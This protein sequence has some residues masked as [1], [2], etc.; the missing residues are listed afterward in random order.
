MKH[1]TFILLIL[2]LIVVL[3]FNDGS[4]PFVE[5]KEQEIIDRAVWY[6]GYK[7]NDDIKYVKTTNL[8]FSE[9]D[10]ELVLYSSNLNENFIVTLNKNSDPYT[11]ADN[12]LDVKFKR[13][14]ERYFKDL[15]SNYWKSYKV[16]NIS[17]QIPYIH[18]MHNGTSLE[19]Y[20]KSNA[21]HLDLFIVVESD[22]ELEL[23]SVNNFAYILSQMGVN[24]NICLLSVKNE[25]YITSN[26]N[27]F[28]SDII[29]SGSYTYYAGINIQNGTFVISMK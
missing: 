7:Y 12:Y 6:M 9:G 29:N 5:G 26:L 23:E 13:E 11:Y 2:I 8:D 21:V 28:Y 15:V 4:I 18:Y 16:V 19:E 10:L 17:K 3:I 14:I 25:D 1:K 24:C 22:V 20:L 27:N